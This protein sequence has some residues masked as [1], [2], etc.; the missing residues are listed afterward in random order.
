[1]DI[2]ALV[3]EYRGNLAATAMSVKEYEGFDLETPC[4]LIDD[5]AVIRTSLMGLRRHLPCSS[6]LASESIQRFILLRSEHGFDKAFELCSSDD[7]DGNGEEFVR[8][9]DEAQKDLEEGV[10]ITV[11][12]LVA[13]AEQARQGW[14][15]VQR[16]MLVVARS[17]DKVTS[18][19]VSVEWV[20]AGR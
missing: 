13:M 19:T 15:E 4:A 12:D 3:K 11:N 2:E 18:G 6:A 16:R 17:G 5:G 1:M 14:T 7:P 10:V 8:E 20:L 9:W